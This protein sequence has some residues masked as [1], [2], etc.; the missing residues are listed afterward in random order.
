MIPP[1]PFDMYVETWKHLKQLLIWW[2]CHQCDQRALWRRRGWRRTSNLLMSPTA[3]GRHP[4]L[5][6]RLFTI[7]PR[8]SCLEC[9]TQGLDWAPGTL[10]RQRER[11]EREW[12]QIE[13]RSQMLPSSSPKFLFA[14]SYGF[15]GWSVIFGTYWR[16]GVEWSTEFALD[17]ALP[18]IA[19]CV[20]GLT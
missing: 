7:I 12:G 16:S 18:S 10:L 14:P 5:P 19:A 2:W 17:Q 8:I 13:A 20:I 3:G 4:E 15:Q 9:N 6:V 11:R 1:L